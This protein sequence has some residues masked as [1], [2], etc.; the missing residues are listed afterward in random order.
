MRRLTLP[1]LLMIVLPGFAAAEDIRTVTVDGHAEIVTP[2]D[3]A[4][5]R[6]G[7][8]ARADTVEAARDRVADVVS[9]F[10]ALTRGLGI[11]DEQVSTAAAIVRP[12]Y[13]WNPQTR[14][15]RLLGYT[16]TRELVV[17]LTDLE[18]LGQL[19]E[20]ALELGVNQV[21]PPALDTTRRAELER[22]ALAAAARDAQERARALAEALGARLG[23]VRSLQA[24]AS[25]RP[26]VP[27]ARGMLAA[28]AAP[29]PE[30]YQTGQITV[31]GSVTASFDLVLP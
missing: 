13:D 17:D 7:V 16:V 18:K 20:S 9:R 12:E 26:P 23:A 5:L 11:T 10:L 4:T 21:D 29:G 30:T 24:A 3:K 2:P 8:E 31:D 6:L 28:E 1:V 19:T 22:Q 25:F 14:E 27:M 15:R